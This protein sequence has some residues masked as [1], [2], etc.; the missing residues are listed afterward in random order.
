MKPVAPVPPWR[1][2]QT[3]TIHPYHT[4]PLKLVQEGWK[5]IE[6]SLLLSCKNQ[7][8]R[9]EAS[10]EW[11]LRKKITNPY[12]AVFSG[13][14]NDFPSLA[15]ATLKP[16]SRSYFKMIEILKTFDFWSRAPKVFT[17]AHICEGPGGF[18]QAA[19][20]GSQKYG[21]R[22]SHLYGMTLKPTK[23][24]IPGWR[25]SSSFLRSHP[26][27]LL[28]Y[29]A[30]GTGNILVSQNQDAFIARSKG[31]YLFTADGGFDFSL[32]YSKQELNAFPLLLA[33]FQVGLRTLCPGGMMIIKLFDMYSQA[34]QDLI[35]GS[36][37]WFQEFT[38]YK[39]ATSRPGNAERY[40]VGIG[41]K[42]GPGVQQW[43]RHLQTPLTR[44]T[45]SPWPQE[46]QTAMLEQILWQENLQ[47]QTIEDTIHLRTES[48]EDR[49]QAAYISSREWLREFL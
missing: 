6:H 34:T 18:I 38:I 22:I 33:S 13:E 49:L 28:E 16:L 25:R 17:T 40:F 3:I 14:S 26:E 10:S 20:A 41:Y 19:V 4:P 27:V 7:I 39:P 32:D 12:E 21:K 45:A 47:I 42:A 44:L 9:L 11:E 23:S 36:A 31:S 2:T 15:P 35:L 1:L 29:G 37:V 8:A 48:L 46:I 30:D 5:E 43:I 24:H